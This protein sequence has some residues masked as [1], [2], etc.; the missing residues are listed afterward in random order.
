MLS[1]LN[2]HCVECCNI[3][4]G[5]DDV[6]SN[7][8]IYLM[9]HSN[10]FIHGYLN[11]KH[12][13]THMYTFPWITSTGHRLCCYLSGSLPYVWRHITLNKNML[14]MLLNKNISFLPSMS[15]HLSFSHYSSV[16]DAW[17]KI[18][19]CQWGKYLHF[20]VLM[21]VYNKNVLSTL[22]EKMQ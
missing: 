9:T 10:I 12:T 14:S 13:H 6:K 21:S 4:V 11:I 19:P 8:N 1:C 17:S 18:D 15:H 3:L 16:L 2:H 5:F 20:L 22:C 7:F